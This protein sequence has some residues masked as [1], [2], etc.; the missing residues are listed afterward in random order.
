MDL[1]Q[2]GYRFRRDDRYSAKNSLRL[3]NFTIYA[4][5]AQEVSLIGDFNQWNPTQ[6]LMTKKIDGY[7]FVQ[8]SLHHGHHRYQFLIDGIP[9]LDPNAQG[10]T[11]NEKN[12]R[13]SLIA[14]S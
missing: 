3:Q 13:V 6:N 7:W 4:P 5:E 11:R 12:E 8:V 14:I 10:V 2:S 9:T 1:S